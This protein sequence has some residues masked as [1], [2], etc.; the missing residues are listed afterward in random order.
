M[1]DYDKSILDQQHILDSREPEPIEWVYMVVA[2]DQFLRFATS[3]ETDAIEEFN[4]YNNG[5]AG[6]TIELCKVDRELFSHKD[7]QAAYKQ[8]EIIETKTL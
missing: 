3:D 4:Y 7:W 8:S 5:Y 6:V 1:S 2:D